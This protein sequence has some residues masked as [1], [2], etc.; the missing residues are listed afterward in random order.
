M[1]HTELTNKAIQWLDAQHHIVQCRPHSY[2]PKEIA[3]AIGGAYTAL[4]GVADA[5]VTELRARGV[6]IRYERINNKRRFTLL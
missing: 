2:A 1:N 4:G 5:V 3:D 6:D